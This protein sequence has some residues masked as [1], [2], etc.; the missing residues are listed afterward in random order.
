[1]KKLLLIGLLLLLTS[2][3]HQ[4]I[5]PIEERQV[6]TVH[7]VN[8]SKDKIFDKTLEWMAVTFTDSK[9]VIE[10]KDKENGK[11]VGKGV[12]SFIR[13][14]IA[15]IQFRFTMVIDIKDKKY[16]TTYSNYSQVNYNYDIQTDDEILIVKKEM[17]SIDNSLNL[18]ILS[19]HNN[20]QW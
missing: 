3:I 18:F 10:I 20:D 11:I 17:L 14:G 12:A 4:K 8:M 16:R 19:S 5:V 7:E 13:G 6:Q 2:C 15:N 1:M 9:A